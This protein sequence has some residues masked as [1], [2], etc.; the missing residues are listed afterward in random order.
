MGFGLFFG[1]YD[2]E[3]FVLFCTAESKNSACF[4]KCIALD[5]ESTFLSLRAEYV[6]LS[7]TKDKMIIGCHWNLILSKKYFSIVRDS[8][9][10]FLPLKHR[11]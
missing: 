1:V 7:S 6:V 10:F 11:V 5:K 4:T 2:N 9:S 8:L 3:G